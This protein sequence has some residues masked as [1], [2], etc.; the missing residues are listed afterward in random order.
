L[1]SAIELGLV[2]SCHDLSEGGLA[3]AIAE[4]CFAGGIGAEIEL[5]KVPTVGESLT[6]AAVLFSES[7]TRFL[8]EVAS[9]QA[10]SFER[11][12]ASIPHACIGRTDDEMRL[13]IVEQVGGATL[14]DS[15]LA[16]L[17]AAWKKPLAW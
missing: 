13:K 14:I 4:M 12:L 8:C 3:V 17:K 1:H 2:R 15:E 6:P 7:N 9:E 5:S 10:D 16:V 11:N